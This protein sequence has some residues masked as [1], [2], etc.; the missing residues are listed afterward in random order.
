MV[1]SL[2]WDYV[3]LSWGYVGLSWGQCGPILGLCW[4]ILKAIWTH[5]GAMLAHLGAMLAHLAAYVRPCWPILSHKI[6]K[7]G[8]QQ[9][10]LRSAGGPSL[11]QRR[12]MPYGKD[13]ATW[14]PRAP[15]RIY[16]LTRDSRPGAQLRW[17][18]LWLC[19]PMLAYVGLSC[20]HCMW[21]QLGAMLAQLGAMFAYLED[22]VG[23]CWPI[24]SHKVRKNGKTGSAQNTVKRFSFWRQVEV[25]G[26]GG[27]LSLLQSWE[28]VWKQSGPMLSTGCAHVAMLSHLGPILG[29]CWAK[30]GPCWAI[31][32]AHLGPIL[33]QVGPM[34]GYVGFI[35]GPCGPM[36]AHV[37]PSWELCWGHVWAIYVETILGCQFSRAG[38]LP[39]AQ[40]HVKT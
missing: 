32:W 26:R 9:K 20:G 21:A 5:L 31:C 37:E 27:G 13:T 4:P 11:L 16:A 36:L 34:L 7:I 1:G 38:P 25:G 40:N 19:W 28:T 6:Q 15:G 14:A 24:L 18:I 23:R 39:G 17:P 29:L 10:F 3:G 22:Y 35:L 8:P 33:A 30:S 12:E 2:S